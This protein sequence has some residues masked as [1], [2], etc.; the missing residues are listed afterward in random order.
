MTQKP[1]RERKPKLT[2]AERHKRFLETAREVEASD[3]PKDF[4]RAFDKVVTSKGPSR[5]RT[6]TNK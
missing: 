2:D 4:D 1:K 6:D 3:D 5:H